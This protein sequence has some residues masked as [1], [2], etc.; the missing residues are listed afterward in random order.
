MKQVTEPKALKG[1]FSLEHNIKLFVP[2]TTKV[3]QDGAE[4]QKIYETKALELMSDLFGGA[5]SYKAIGA[6]K[7]KLGLVTEK[8]KIV[9]SYGTDVQM[10]NGIES[11]IGLAEEIKRE[12]EQESVAIEYDNK[13]YFV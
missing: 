9:E 8:V 2:S 12:M 7:S 5:T 1:L 6:W 11:V 13:L 4:L 10:E 3:N